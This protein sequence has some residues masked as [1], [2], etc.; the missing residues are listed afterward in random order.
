MVWVINNA[1]I[2]LAA[3]INNLEKTQDGTRSHSDSKGVS[4]PTALT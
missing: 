3:A 4:R 1:L 2:T